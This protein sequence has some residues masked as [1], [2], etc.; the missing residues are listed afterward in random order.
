[1]ALPD[2]MKWSYLRDEKNELK[3]I[4]STLYDFHPW[5]SSKWDGYPCE[6][7]NFYDFIFIGRNFICQQSPGKNKK[8]WKVG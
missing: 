2:T 7:Y 8:R 4:V 3:L 6:K 1:M 5:A